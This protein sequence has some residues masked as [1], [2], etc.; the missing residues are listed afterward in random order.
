M[1]R[2][3]IIIIEHFIVSGER[4]KDV[5][6]ATFNAI[7]SPSRIQ[8]IIPIWQRTYSWE[9]QHWE[10]L[11]QDLLDLY[12]RLHK[13]ES[14]HHFMGPIVLKTIEEKVGEITRRVIIDGQQR[15]TT[16][17]LLCALIRDRSKAAGNNELVKYIEDHLLFNEYAKKAED[18]PK[19]RPTEGDRKFFESILTGESL[20]QSD[21]SNQLVAAYNFY[22]NVFENDKEKFDI[23][24]LLDCIESLKMVT[25]RLEEDDNPNRIFETLNFRGKELAQS[26]LVRN[27]FMMAIKDPAKADEIYTSVWFPM[28]QDLGLSTLERIKNLETFLRHFIVMTKHEVIKEDKVY[29][30]VRERLKYSNEDQVVSEL[31]TINMH[32]K[33]YEKLLYPTRE[34]S[35]EIR[36]GVERLNRL[37]VL[38]HY[39]FLLK[40]YEGFSEGKITKED[41]RTILKTIESY[42]VRRIFKRMPTNSLNR[43]F[44]DLCNLPEE[45]IA[46]SLQNSIAGKQSWTA[47]YWPNDDEFKEQFKTVP[48]YRISSEKCRFVLE[49]LEEAFEHPEEVKFENLWIE[50][51]MPETL[52]SKWQTYLGPDWKNTHD[53]HLHTIGNL[54]LIAPSPNESIT[55]KLFFKKK[56]EWYIH[57]NI[58]LTKEI[59][60]KWNEWREPQ[61]QQRASILAER[62]A[63]IWPRPK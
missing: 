60:E 40:V 26:D 53:N 11:W 56:K 33:Y 30:K 22:K 54:T 8:F 28:Q 44:A 46:L 41:F 29:S 13:G 50:H 16:L 9:P 62:A 18:K 35:P 63:K 31:R 20:P 23:E 39:P 7:I 3:P 61:I 42:I 5:T 1:L 51:I 32:S 10:D 49:S 43:L 58:S 57:S 25:I 48:I 38:V 52:D 2:K 6:E 59:S 37:K 36:K 45:N 14:A 21:Y 17:L 27:F 47:Q 4:L 19:L 34:N 55:N 15:L 24:G 12:E